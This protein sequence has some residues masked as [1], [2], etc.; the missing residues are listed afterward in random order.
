MRFLLT[1]VL[2]LTLASFCFAQ[3]PS[4]SPAQ[5]AAEEKPKLRDFG[6]SVESFGKK[7]RNNS[8]AEKGA[9]E[10]DDDDVIR[11]KTDLVVSDVLVVNQKGNLITGLDESDFVITEDRVPQKV[12]T[13]S[14]GENSTPRSIVL[15]IDYS[16][17]QFHY[18][19]NSIEAAKKLVDK[20]APKDR[21]AIVTDDVE[22]LTGFTRD[23][24]KLKNELDKQL[25][26]KVPK[27]G[28]KSLQYSALVATLNE[29]FDEEDV[30]P[31]IIFQTDGDELQFLKGEQTFPP[32]FK[33][34]NFS[35]ADIRSLVSRSRATIYTVMPGFRMLG[36]S[37]KEQ[38]AI[39]ARMEDDAYR[40]AAE[41]RGEKNSKRRRPPAPG[42]IEYMAREIEK[43]Q[44]R[45]FDIST[46]SGGYMDFIERPEDADHVYDNVFNVISNRYVIGYYPTNKERNGK[47]REVKIEVRGHPEYTVTGRK[48]YSLN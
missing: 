25:G 7:P 23:K 20:L 3:T 41:S 12:S 37:R 29:M 48:A 43:Q 39:S 35:F 44:L 42:F 8:A 40:E 36:L 24:A 16:E 46:L 27:T 30:R 28:G 47:K 34:R 2:V 6:S 22:L 31:I 9:A 13:F 18:I 4:A 11:I 19:K 26:E 45:L 32:Y 1:F 21:M 38:L 33:V 5:S 17:S 14:F 15:I 10:T